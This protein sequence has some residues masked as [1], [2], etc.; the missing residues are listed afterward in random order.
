MTTERELAEWPDKIRR[1]RGQAPRRQSSY[2][3]RS[4]RHKGLWLRVILFIGGLSLAL[5]VSNQFQ[6]QETRP[7]QPQLFQGDRR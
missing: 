2:V 1:V 5:A 3:S 6:Q 7:T 4:R